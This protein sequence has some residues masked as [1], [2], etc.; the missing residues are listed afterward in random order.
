M[1]EMSGFLTD[2]RLSSFKKVCSPFVH[3]SFGPK[4]PG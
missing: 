1:A 4:S 2:P 3:W